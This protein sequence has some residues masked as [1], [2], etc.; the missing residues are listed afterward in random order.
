MKVCK[1]TDAE[2]R[3]AGRPFQTAAATTKLRVRST[4]LECQLW[5]D[6]PK[7]RRKYCIDIQDLGQCLLL[8]VISTEGRRSQ[9]R[10]P[11]LGTERAPVGREQCET[12]R[13]GES[14]R[15]LRAVLPSQTAAPTLQVL[16][17]Q[18]QRGTCVQVCGT[19]RV[20]YTP[21]DCHSTGVLACGYCSCTQH[22]DVI[23]SL[24]LHVA[25]SAY[26]DPGRT[27]II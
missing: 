12:H 9:G 7:H 11:V 8:V 24:V 5:H 4:V 18:R 22:I 19:A 10:R 3:F 1:G 15:R 25:I 16:V 20:V 6:T 2:R 23:Q 13:L 27:S 17:K 14:Q 21:I 26:C